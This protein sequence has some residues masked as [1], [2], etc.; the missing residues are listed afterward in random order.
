LI[1][2]FVYRFGKM[3]GQQQQHKHSTGAEDE[4]NRVKTGGGGN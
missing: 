4:Q 2:T 3:N 1:F